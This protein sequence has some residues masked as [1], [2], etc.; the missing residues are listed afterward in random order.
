MRTT[1]HILDT[2]V[3]ILCQYQN[4]CRKYWSKQQS[5]EFMTLGPFKHLP[6]HQ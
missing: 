4:F 3:S 2:H 1:Q 6:S 5:D